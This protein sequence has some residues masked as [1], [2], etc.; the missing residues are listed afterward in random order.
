[1]ADQETGLVSRETRPDPVLLWEG[2]AAMF[3]APDGGRV[4]RYEQDG[5]EKF[6]AIPGELVPA[7]ELLRA[8]PGALIAISQSPMGGMARRMVGQLTRKAEAANGHDGG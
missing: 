8:N 1:M 2:P 4:I 6:V 5:E 7:L 3:A